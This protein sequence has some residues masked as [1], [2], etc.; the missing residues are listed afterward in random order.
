MKKITEL[1]FPRQN[2][3]QLAAGILADSLCNAK[4]KICIRVW[5]VRLITILNCAVIPFQKMIV[6]FFSPTSSLDRIRQV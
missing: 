2:P 1:M 6:H 3:R 4:I 5:L